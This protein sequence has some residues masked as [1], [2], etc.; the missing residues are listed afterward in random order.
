VS[1]SGDFFDGDVAEAA[2][3]EQAERHRLQLRD[4]HL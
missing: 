2:L 1:F 4:H 3:L